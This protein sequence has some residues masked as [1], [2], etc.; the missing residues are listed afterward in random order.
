MVDAGTT[1]AAE[2]ATSPRWIRSIAPARRTW[3]SWSIAQRTTAMAMAVAVGVGI[4]LRTRGMFDG[5]IPLWTDEALWAL[6]LSE[7]QGYHPLRPLGF[8]AVTHALTWAFSW[9]EVALRLLPWLSGVGALLL[10][11]PLAKNLFKTEGA[12]LVFVTAL[13]LNPALID[14]GKEFK[15]YC[16]SVLVHLLGMLLALVYWNTWR[17]RYLW[18]AGAW[19]VL[20]L[21]FAQ[22]V[23]FAYP[24]VFAVLGW[25]ALR[26]GSR[27]ALTLVIVAGVASATAVLLVYTFWWSALD[28]GPHGGEAPYWARRY[29]VFYSGEESYL[30]WLLDKQIELAGAPGIRRTLWSEDHPRV[31]A[32]VLWSWGLLHLAGLV[33]LAVQ[34]RGRDAALL[35][36]PV[37]VLLLFNALGF[38]PYGV[39]RTNLFLMLYL[40][41]IASVAL[42]WSRPRWPLL[43][44]GVTLALIIAPLLAFERNW[45]AKKERVGLIGPSAM[46]S[47]IL[48]LLSLKQHGEVGDERERLLVSGPARSV[49][50]YYTRLHPAYVEQ[51]KKLRAQFDVTT[52]NYSDSA[53]RSASRVL[54]RGLPRVWILYNQAETLESLQ[55]AL[56]RLHLR[57]TYD[58]AIGDG[59]ALL[60]Q[61]EPER[62]RRR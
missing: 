2:D 23:I 62:A 47:A 48:R 19:G 60:I 55:P 57:A 38:W 33:T 34:R 17:E 6:K 7:G 54:R 35:F 5:S 25:A 45:H 37:V 29:G 27:R 1:L 43:A 49:F 24:A 26:S 42:D 4:W 56:A 14:F 3:E 30:R 8:M 31:A 58:E 18:L 28:A 52:L 16:V 51:A 10:A 15:P 41:G 59:E 22:D 50:T 39:F 46:T 36:V 61:V 32:L 11:L 40:T 21:H 9:R 12:R 20:S 13:A 44:W 53:L